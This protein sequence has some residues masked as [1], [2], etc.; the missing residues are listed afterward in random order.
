MQD[1]R[2]VL[3]VNK[4]SAAADVLKGSESVCRLW[5]RASTANELWADL[6]ERDN[7]TEFSHFEC[8]KAA[9]ELE[10]KAYRLVALDEHQ[11]TV[12]NCKRKKWI[13]QALATE[14]IKATD[15][16]LAMWGNQVVCC[17]GFRRY[18][19]YLISLSGE[20]AILPD[21]LTPR[22]RH[23]T[24]IEQGR[25]YA[26][27]GL[28]QCGLRCCETLSLSSPQLW[29]RLPDMRF[30]HH[31]FSPFTVRGLVY[32]WGGGTPRVETFS[33]DSG[34]FTVIGVEEYMQS[35][36]EQ[37]AI[38]KDG[39]LYLVATNFRI[40]GKTADFKLS[41]KFHN[42]MDKLYSQACPVLCNGLLFTLWQGVI[43]SLDFAGG[44]R[45]AV[46]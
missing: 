7:F 18:S 6:A 28:N 24:V 8:R 4:F 12:Y 33:L 32:I 45:I 38:V 25:L 11:L 44:H 23:G 14:V 17:G 20:V 10:I 34:L 43:Y 1:F 35:P 22:Y 46:H 41:I 13:R 19:A 26:F 42:N 21:M 2:C 9:Y 30:V 27:G 29:E 37:C 31:S 15:M 3:E 40:T 39:T 16:T 36:G 5:N